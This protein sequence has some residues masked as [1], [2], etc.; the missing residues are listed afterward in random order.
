MSEQLLTRLQRSFLTV[1][2]WNLSFLPLPSSREYPTTQAV[3]APS[4]PA[5][6]LVTLGFATWLWVTTLPAEASQASQAHAV[7]GKRS[8]GSQAWVGLWASRDGAAEA[9]VSRGS[10]DCTCE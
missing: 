6:G 9:G 8:R 5:P 7:L 1:Q 10:S 3:G 4:T 2:V